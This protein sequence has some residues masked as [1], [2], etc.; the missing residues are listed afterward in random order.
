[1]AR[2]P[3]DPL[4]SSASRATARVRRLAATG[5]TETRA[6]TRAHSR[7]VDADRDELHRVDLAERLRVLELVLRQRT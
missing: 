5:P 3:R 2:A 6:A 4:D 1:M 7:R